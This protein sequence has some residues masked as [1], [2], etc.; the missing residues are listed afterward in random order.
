VIVNGG[1][2]EIIDVDE[3]VGKEH[4]FKVFKRTVGSLIHDFIP[5][6]ADLGYLGIES[7]HE[8]S[9]IPVKASK[10]HPLSKKDKA[11][12]KRLARIR[13]LVEHITAKI[14]TFKSM[15]YPYRN[16]CKRHLLR[17]SLISGIINYEIGAK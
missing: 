16:H 15:A 10:L 2:K 3:G 7:L 13:V 12:N 8:N 11:Y 4:D 1:T 17:A 5:V 9:K 6:Y 14:K